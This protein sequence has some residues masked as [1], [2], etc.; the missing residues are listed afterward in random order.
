MSRKSEPNRWRVVRVPVSLSTAWS[1]LVHAAR[2]QADSKAHAL[3]TNIHK[4]AAPV[5][6]HTAI[7]ARRAGLAAKPHAVAIGVGVVAAGLVAIALARH[8]HHH[9]VHRPHNYLLDKFEW[10]R[11]WH[12][13]RFHHHV[14]AGALVVFML[15]V[16]FNTGLFKTV[17]ASDVTQSWTFA[18]AGD[19]TVSDSNAVEIT[20][21]SARLK[22][23]NYATDANTRALFHLDESS[24][25]NVSD[26]SGNTNTGTLTGG[27][28]G[29]GN[30]NNAVTL[31]GS[32]DNFSAP[33]SPS[34]S[35]SQNNSLEAWTK[36]ANNFAPG[37]HDNKQGIIDKGAYKLYYDQE[38][39]KVTYELANAGANSWTQQAGN[40]TKGSWDLNGKLAVNA[41]VAIGSDIYVGL[42]NAVGDAEV[43][44]WDGTN[45]AQVGGDGQN[46]SWADQ[47]YENVVS[48]ASDGNTLYAGLGSSAG[49]GEVWSCDAGSGCTSWTKIGGDGINSGWGVNT[50][51]QIGAMTVMNNNLYV[52]L[53]LTATADARVYR[54]NGSSWL[55]VGGNGITT[56]GYNAF[57]TLYEGVFRL[58]NDGTSIYAGFGSSAGDADVWRLT[59]TTWTQIGGDAINSSWA[60]A[61]YETVVSLRYFNGNLYAGLGLTAG[62]AEVWAWNGS[63][64]AQIGGDSLNSSWDTTYEGVYSFTDDGTNLYAGLGTTAGDNE[65]WKWNGATW[66]KIGGDGVNSSFTN[67]HTQVNELTYNGGLLYAGLVGTGSNAEVWAFDGTNWSQIGGG[68]VNNSWGYFNLQ[69]VETMTVSGDYLYAGTGNTVAGNAQVWRF[70]G[71]TWRIVGGQGLNSSWAIKSY[72]NVTSMISYAGS[73]YVGLGTTSG[74]GEV[75]MFNGA[76]WSQIGGDAVNSSWSTGFEEVSSMAVF[77]GEL[78]AGLGNS[79]NDAEVWRWNGSAWSKIGGDSLNN[80]WTINYEQVESLIPYNGQLYAGLGNSTGDA[81]VW[82]FNGSVWAQ[83]GGDGIGSSWVDGQYEQAKSLVVYNGQLYVGLGN[84]AGD[85]EVWAYNSSNSTWTR[86]AGG[87]VNASWAANTIETVQSFSTYRGKL[88]AGLGN[89]ANSDA[90]I[91][92]YGNNGFLQSTTVGQDTAWHHIAGSYDGTTLKLFIDGHLDSQAVISQSLPDTDQ[93]LLVGTTYG[94]SESGIGQG[95]FKGSIDE[96]RISNIARPN[97][98]TLPYASTPQ[99]LSPAAVYP[100]GIAT[101]DSF[102]TSETPAGGAI[103][104]RLSANGGTTWLYWTGSVW[105]TSTSLSEANP[106]AIID[107]QLATFPVTPGGFKWQAILSGNGTQRVQLDSVSVDATADIT[108]PPAATALTMLKSA[109]GATIASNDW[110]NGAEPYFSWTPPTDTQSAIRGYCMYVGTDGSADPATTKGLLGTTPADNTGVTCPFV[111]ATP[112]I[113]FATPSLRGSTWLTSATAPYYL[114][115]K[116]IDNAGNLSASATTA[117]FRFDNTAPTNPA[118]ITTPSQFVASKTVT[119]TWPITGPNAPDDTA[120]GLVGLQYRIG[121]SG[122]WYGDGHTGAQDSS[123]V[124]AGDGTYTTQDPPDFDNLIEGNNN[125]YVRAWDVA[126]N[127]STAYV[128]GVIRLNTS[129]PSGPQNVTASPTVNTANSFAFSW[130]PPA[131]FVGSAGQITYCYTI[132]TLPTAGSCTFTGPGVTS[133]GASAYATQ[134]GDNTFYVVA[135]DEAGNINYATHSEVTFT[136]NTA[137]PGIPLNVEI[138]DISV[139]ATNNWKLAISWEP[140]ADIGSGI[141]SYKI[142]RSSDNISYTVVASNSGASFVD[143]GLLQQRYYYKVKA[144]DSANNCGASTTAVDDLPTGRFTTAA[145]ITSQPTLVNVS[146]RRATITWSTDRASDS[147]IALGTASGT[148]SGDEIANSDQVTSHSISLSNLQSGTTYYYKAKWTDEDGN[149]GSSAEQSFSTLPAPTVKEVS[150]RKIALNSA[151]VQFTTREAVKVKVYFGKSE[152]F[153]GLQVVNTSTAESTYNVDLTA[154]EDGSK[155]FYKI[156][157]FDADG[158]EYEGNIFSLSTPARPQISNVRFQPV[159]GEPTSTQKITWTTNVPTT[160]LVRYGLTGQALFE[161]YDSATTTEH[162]M[163]IRELQDNSDYVLVAESRDAEGNVALSDAQNFRT[164]LDTRPPVVKNLKVETTIRGTGAEARGQVVVSWDTDE[165]STSQVAYADGS[166]GSTYTNRT[167]EETT[168]VT[169]H[170]VIVSDL[171][172]SKVFHLRAESRDRA[173]NAGTSEDR[174]T[175]IG[176]ASDSVLSIIFNALSKVFSFLR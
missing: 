15:A 42:G 86:V 117:Q 65:V 102:S 81:E 21:T 24:G 147:K 19:Y 37:T 100:S 49:D 66:A 98:T 32:T 25:T 41:Q 151:T 89:T 31:N 99:T 139:K 110:T 154:L 68:Y 61:T 10:Y 152:G 72:E 58:T 11:R 106:K 140:P 2:P 45:W 125:V 9:A 16:G 175:I 116:A 35:L 103:S 18:N 111:V 166:S 137:A 78:Y 27:S 108:A 8:G 69:N 62:D 149:T 91:W 169:Q 128:T 13:T 101:W 53:G 40:D 141:A 156:N 74:D 34:L 144:C 56:P 171:A 107:A 127:V 170:T 48:M 33:D 157:P 145:T 143:T 138:A 158:N 76:S 94:T 64:W 153:G 167:A 79:A 43:W 67:T 63:T 46:S 17:F 120:S 87:G 115:I 129:A 161:K 22:A 146:T 163:V 30:L 55:W 57:P 123:D 148:Y 162:E 136:A 14:H 12:H 105:G 126:G 124:L 92:S 28:F 80:G 96:V 118:F 60:A 104:Y 172:T 88:Y 38:T 173:G 23:Q 84:T 165:P 73:L 90:Q 150:T 5:A 112:N 164:A 26:S 77:A 121:S 93:A 97:F 122:T 134:P 114:R 113:D 36:F 54:W 3:L 52:G 109:G 82:Q 95:Y 160:S 85:G 168:L 83:V 130:L 1:R 135:K 7:L 50:I 4:H 119:F 59:G 6:K 44:K 39:G 29:V 51:E 176:R 155:Y 174:S 142:Y 159:V 71:T 20:G 47:T 133:L 131:S 75:W 70:D 132:N